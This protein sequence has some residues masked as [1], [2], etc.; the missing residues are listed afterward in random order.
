MYN[1]HRLGTKPIWMTNVTF[2]QIWVLKF[3]ISIHSLHIM[4]ARL[5]WTF[6]CRLSFS[7]VKRLLICR[8]VTATTNIYLHHLIASIWQSR[9][10]RKNSTW[11]C[12]SA[13]HL[14]CQSKDVSLSITTSEVSVC[15]SVKRVNCDKTKA[16]SAKVI[17]PPERSMHLVL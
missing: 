5:S 12:I 6:T 9:P 3:P 7:S 14:R 1:L 16:T 2:C 10:F 13:T 8:D 11:A 4:L 15:P 17:I